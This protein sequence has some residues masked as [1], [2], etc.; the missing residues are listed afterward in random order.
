MMMGDWMGSDFTNDDLVRQTSLTK[1]YT[2]EMIKK[3]DEH[4]AQSNS[5]P[6]KFTKF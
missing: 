2:V 3:E 5:P 6:R 1:D 4:Y